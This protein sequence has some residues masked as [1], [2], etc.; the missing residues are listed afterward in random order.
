M[1]KAERVEEK[2]EM[3][4]GCHPN[5]VEKTKGA[6]LLK[7]EHFRRPFRMIIDIYVKLYTFECGSSKVVYWT[8][9]GYI[10]S[11]RSH[12]IPCGNGIRRG[13]PD[14]AALHALVRAMEEVDACRNALERAEARL[15]ARQQEEAAAAVDAAKW[16]Q[17]ED[18][19]EVLSFRPS[20]KR[21]TGQHFEIIISLAVW[22]A[23]KLATEVKCWVFKEN[24][25]RLRNTLPISPGDAAWL[26]N[27]APGREYS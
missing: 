13:E 24:K 23:L 20:Q 4:V 15:A 6:R 17:F 11:I 9:M 8:S 2:I 26:T 27:P 18:E 21:N 7:D 16:E 1:S 12:N 14:A 22:R 5:Q 10:P 19:A 3:V 25:E